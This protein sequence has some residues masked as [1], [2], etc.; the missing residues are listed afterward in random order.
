[1]EAWSRWFRAWPLLLRGRFLEAWQDST[2]FWA[3]ILARGINNSLWLLVFYL[4]FLRFPEV[5]GF[6][7]EDLV[8]TWAMAFGALGLL[9]VLWGGVLGLARLAE[10]G[11]LEVHLALPVPPLPYLLSLRLQPTGLGDLLWSMGTLVFLGV[12]WLYALCALIGAS[13]VALGFFLALASLSLWG[14]RVQSLLPV[15][16]AGLVQFATWPPNVYKPTIKAL[17]LSLIPAFWLGP[18]PARAVLEG[19]GLLTLWAS[20]LGFFAL[21]SVGFWVGLRRYVAPGG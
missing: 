15:A 21:G 17:L 20:G 13:L 19:S 9:Q 4:F 6:R 18:L 11:E 10:T 8:L 5:R 2:G 14:L 3:S 7:F 16:Y 12:N 1:M